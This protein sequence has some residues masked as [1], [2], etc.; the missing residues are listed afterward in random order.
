MS[1][2]ARKYIRRGGAGA[3]AEPAADGERAAKAAAAEEEEAA[4][5]AMGAP[6]EEVGA[7]RLVGGMRAGVRGAVS[8]EVGVVGSVG[9]VRTEMT[10]RGGVCGGGG[11]A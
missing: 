1:S 9:V 4:A 7:C 11:G 2:G 6:R 10:V 3:A 8:G 5:V